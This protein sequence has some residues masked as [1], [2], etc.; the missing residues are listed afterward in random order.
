MTQEKGQPTA[1]KTP[2]KQWSEMTKSEKRGAI[3]V[4]VVIALIIFGIIGAVTG[5]GND[6]ASENTNSGTSQTTTTETV[7]EAEPIEEKGFAGG[8]YKVGTDMPAGEYVIVGS[9]YL[10]I[11]SDSSGSFESIVENDNYSNRTIILVSDGQYVQFSGR[12]YTPADA[13][14]VDA[15]SGT[16]PAGKY[17]VGTDFPAGEYKITP[18]G[19]GYYG[20]STSA[21][22]SLDSLVSNDNFDT[23]RYLTVQ[24]GQYLKLNRATI[25]L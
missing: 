24:D 3:I 25:K 5:G 23:E 20:I 2:P 18:S 19:S 12:A 13:P 16:L 10:Q 22:E 14:K 9:G 4:L 7:A 15:S 11:S 21:S 17:K 1:Q 6:T 8:M